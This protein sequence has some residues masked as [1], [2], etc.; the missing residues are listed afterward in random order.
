MWRPRL[1]RSIRSW[2]NEIFAEEWAKPAG[3]GSAVSALN[4]LAQAGVVS[5]IHYEYETHGPP[6]A[7]TFACT[8]SLTSASELRQATEIGDTKA[9]AKA[10]AAKA[11]L[12][13]VKD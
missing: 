11:L 6:H 13:Q 1:E 8:A 12:D 9:A 2:A 3:G 5:D 10:S 4:E 7:P